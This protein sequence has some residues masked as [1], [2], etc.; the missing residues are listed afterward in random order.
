[1]MGGWVIETGEGHRLPLGI[2]RQID[3]EAQLRV[4]TACGEDTDEAVFAC[5]DTEALPDDGGVVVLRD[6]AGGEVASFAYGDAG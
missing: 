4:H 6:S 3:P 1:D 5:L 2:G